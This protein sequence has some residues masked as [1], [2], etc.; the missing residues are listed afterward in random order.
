MARL[1]HRIPAGNMQLVI[2][3]SGEE[4]F[5]RMLSRVATAKARNIS[6]NFGFEA[7]LAHKIY[8][9]SDIFLMPS[10]YEPCGLGQLIALRY[11][12]V[13]VVRKTGGLADTICRSAMNR[14]RRPGFPSIPTPLL[15]CGRR[16]CALCGRWHD[17]QG[18]GENGPER[19]VLPISPGTI[20]HW[21]MRT[22]T[23]VASNR[24]RG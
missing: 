3:G 10:H 21:N 16:Y 6:I 5:M 4:K 15:R 9:G 22:C 19:D 11:G 24:K 18:V 13:P 17:K 1:L 7:S 23:N 2:L 14:P 12:T 8:A 20:P